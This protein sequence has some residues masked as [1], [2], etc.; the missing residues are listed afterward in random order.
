MLLRA[1]AFSV[2]ADRLATSS[3]AVSN[4]TAMPSLPLRFIAAKQEDRMRDRWK[5]ALIAAAALSAPMSAQAQTGTSDDMM[6]ETQDRIADQRDGDVPWDLLGLLGLAG[7]LGLR[8]SSD[9][10]GYT[11]D[12]I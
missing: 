6:S 5:A 10:D 11:D 7:L 8:R 12:P 2:S 9:N 3:I 1:F 4:G